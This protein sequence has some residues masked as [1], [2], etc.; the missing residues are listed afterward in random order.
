MNKEEEI[1]KEVQRRLDDAQF[2]K[3]LRSSFSVIPDMINSLSELRKSVESLIS[4]YS[5]FE[6]GQNRLLI[7]SSDINK[8]L[9]DLF[10]KMRKLDDSYKTLEDKLVNKNNQSSLVEVISKLIKEQDERLT[11]KNNPKSI[12]SVLKKG[13]NVRS[14]ITWAILATVGILDVVG[15]FFGE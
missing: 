10:E 1:E 12:I 8:E 4:E 14:I 13:S 5:K 7:E 6:G 15:R 3:D 2:R 11:D 9:N